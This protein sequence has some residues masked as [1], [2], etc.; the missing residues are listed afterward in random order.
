MLASEYKRAFS[1]YITETKSHRVA[2][3]IFAVAFVI[4]GYNLS[5]AEKPS[6]I[7][8]PWTLTTEAKISQTTADSLYYEAWGLA[9]ATLLG[10]IHPDNVDFT[11]DAIVPLIVPDQRRTITQAMRAEV[12]TLKKNNIQVS[13][14]PQ[15][16]SVKGNVVTVSGTQV[17]TTGISDAIPQP[18]VYEFTLSI[19]DYMLV[20]EWLEGYPEGHKCD[21]PN[22]L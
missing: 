8:Q 15:A 6:V 14:K 21:Q 13:F 7:L 12:E 5:Q 10:N 22:C 17:R 1:R 18:Y 3:T 20:I 9:L 4:M 11:I 2:N 19:Q 16:R